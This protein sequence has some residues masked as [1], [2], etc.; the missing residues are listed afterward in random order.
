MQ[1]FKVKTDDKTTVNAS[2]WTGGNP[3]GFLIHVISA[4]GYIEHIKLFEYWVSAKTQ[5]DKFTKDAKDV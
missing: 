1:T 5:V 4:I 3:E 2:V